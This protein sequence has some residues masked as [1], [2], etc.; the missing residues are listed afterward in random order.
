MKSL[1]LY[2]Y[3]MVILMISITHVI[4]RFLNDKIKEKKHQ[5]LF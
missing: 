4:I 1:M 5:F 2:F 3:K